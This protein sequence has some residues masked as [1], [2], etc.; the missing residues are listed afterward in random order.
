M[1]IN[2]ENNSKFKR[3]YKKQIERAIKY[4]LMQESKKRN[5]I[6]KNFL[7]KVGIDNIVV[8]LLLTADK[9]IKKYNKKYLGCNT[10]TDVIAFSMIED[11]VIPNNNVLGDI[12]ISL[13]TVKRN[14]EKY[15][16]G[17]K[18]ELM[19]V[20]IHGILHLLGYDHPS[21]DSV[22]RKKEKEYLQCITKIK[23]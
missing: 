14:S 8:N 2:I 23:E 6:Y 10:P 3:I 20:V 16:T 21:E 18:N 15:N 13:E 1:E 9:Q 17:F 12:I 7:K 11:D 19:L 5:K 22:M 4:V